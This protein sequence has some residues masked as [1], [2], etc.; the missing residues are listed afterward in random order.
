MRGGFE[1]K[2]LFLFIP[3]K[4]L[5]ASRIIKSFTVFDHSVVLYLTKVAPDVSTVHI[6]EMFLYK[7]NKLEK[8]DIIPEPPFFIIYGK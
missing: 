3:F 4:W 2:L 7:G 5:P 1:K 8:C 6:E